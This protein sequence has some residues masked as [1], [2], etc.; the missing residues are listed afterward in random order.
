MEGEDRDI[1]LY[2]LLHFVV[3]DAGMLL[4]RT[5]TLIN[6]H[7]LL[8]TIATTGNNPI[9]PVNQ[10]Q[11]RRVCT[12]L[13]QQQNMPE[14]R[15]NSKLASTE[16]Q[17]THEFFLQVCNTFPYSWRP[18]YRFFQ[19]TQQQN[20]TFPHTIVSFNKMLDV[21][22]KSRNIDLFW[23]LL[24]D[25]ARRCFVNDKTFIIALKTLGGARELKKCVEVFHLMNE[26]GFGYNL[27][28]LN[29]VVGAM[30]GCKLVDEAKHVVLKLRD[31]VTPDAVTYRILI[32]GYCDK[33][34]LIEASKVW[35]LMMDDGVRPQLEAYEK[36]MEIFFKKDM[37]GEALKLFRTIRFKRMDELRDSSYKLVIKWLCRKGMM[38]DAQEV[39]DEMRSR[40]IQV[41][42]LTLGSV[43]YGLVSRHRVREA[44]QVAK[45]ID[46]PDISVYHGLI[47]GL[48]RL[49]RARE[50]TE[51]F[52]EMIRRGCE[53]TMHTYIMLL[54]GHLGRRGRK[55]SDPLINFDTIFVGGL[56]KVGKSKEAGKY[57]ERVMNRGLEVPRFDYNKFLHHFSNEE[58]V[59]MFEEMGT[60]LR[61]V[62]LV[63][64]AD[65]FERYGQKMATRDRRRNRFPISEDTKDV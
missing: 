41:D 51:V 29:K 8:T 16:F 58:G 36:M 22:G 15:L 25:M 10:D 31:L 20:P 18:V 24:S 65:I 23:S 47:K 54:Q 49:R 62:G 61:E 3:L 26:N 63:D 50:A 53:P 56:V 59:V 19:Y 13:Y 14:S 55:G 38:C 21:I 5:T 42:N 2:K 17:L 33:G 37:C 46:S 12:I 7:R 4:R 44:Y 32:Q 45:E 43:V 48:V 52:R 30:C 11:L 40:G 34:E 27:E 39:F 57:V 28:T 35:N 9:T 64:L 6:N 60:K 1:F